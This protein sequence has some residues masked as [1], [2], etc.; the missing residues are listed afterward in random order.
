MKTLSPVAKP[1]AQSRQETKGPFFRR[2]SQ[3]GSMF[4]APALQ[5]RLK[6]SQPGDPHEVEAD[7]MAEHVMRTLSE[8]FFAPA[9]PASSAPVP[10][11]SRVPTP[12]SA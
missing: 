10:A 6:V 5:A 8:P 1:G 3:P 9:S 11:I 12:P 4:F 2:Q 7:R